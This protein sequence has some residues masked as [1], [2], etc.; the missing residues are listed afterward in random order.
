MLHCYLKCHCVLKYNNV[1]QQLLKKFQVLTNY[2]SK[3]Q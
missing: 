3:S 2:I 1:L